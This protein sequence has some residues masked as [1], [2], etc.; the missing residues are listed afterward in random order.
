VYNAQAALNNLIYQNTNQAAIQNAL[1]NLV[2]AQNNLAHSQKLYSQVSGDPST[3]PGKANAYQNL[4]AAQLA[5]NSAEASYNLVS[6]K[7]NQTLVD[8]DTAALALAK[9][10]LAEDQT[11]VAALTGGTVPANATG[12]GYDALQQAKL[13]LQTAQENET[14]T[15][16]IAP[17]SGTVMSISNAVGE[18]IGSGTFITIAD[19]SKADVQIFMDPNDWSNIKV[20][21]ESDVTF[22]ASP[23]KPL[24]GR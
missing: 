20:G 9:A 18:T 7:A 23:I 1:A 14:N 3:D 6:G 5:Y 4:Y 2:L 21:Y 17:I 8:S 13:N 12:S 24:S 19:L 16:L 11:L 15:T 10:K 22:D